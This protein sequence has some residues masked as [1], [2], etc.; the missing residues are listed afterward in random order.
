MA[1]IVGDFMLIKSYWIKDFW[2]SETCATFLE[3][4]FGNLEETQKIEHFKP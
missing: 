1:K 2:I 3:K 4:V